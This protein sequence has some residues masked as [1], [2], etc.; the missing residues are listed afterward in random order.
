V[1]PGPSLLKI[2][3]LIIAED[4]NTY[5]AEICTILRMPANRSEAKRVA[6]ELSFLHTKKWGQETYRIPVFLELP[7]E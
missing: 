1:T 5:L 2:R 4:C 7:T 6:E 3:S